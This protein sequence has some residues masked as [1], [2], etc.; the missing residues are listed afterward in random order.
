M[1]RLFSDFSHPAAQ[2]HSKFPF[3]YRLS[4]APSLAFLSAGTGGAVTADGEEEAAARTR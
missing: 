1:E 2:C 4:V 3:P